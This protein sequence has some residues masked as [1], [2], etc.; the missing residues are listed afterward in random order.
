[1]WVSLPPAA[2]HCRKPIPAK[3]EIG[4]E[5]FNVLEIKA[6]NHERGFGHGN[7]DRSAR[8]SGLC[9]EGGIAFRMVI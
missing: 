7:D 8:E 4:N 2:W 3:A 6:H 9:A 1:M 5:T